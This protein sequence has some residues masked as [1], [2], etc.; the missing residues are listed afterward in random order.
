MKT[1]YEILSDAF[2]EIKDNHG[3]ALETIDFNVIRRMDGDA[4]HGFIE[5]EGCI[6]PRREH[7]DD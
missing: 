7:N 4:H 6:V 1:I 5:T 3:I 2:I